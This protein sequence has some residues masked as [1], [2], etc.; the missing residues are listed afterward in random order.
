M[1]LSDNALANLPGIISFLVENIAVVMIVSTSGLG[2]P[3]LQGSFK[4]AD[5]DDG[6]QKWILFA[7]SKVSQFQMTEQNCTVDTDIMKSEL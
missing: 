5:V 7:P 3:G 6:L 4:L 2:M 1:I